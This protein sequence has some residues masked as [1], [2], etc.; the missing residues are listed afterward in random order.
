MNLIIYINGTALTNNEGETHSLPYVFFKKVIKSLVVESYHL[1]KP[2]SGP[3]GFLGVIAGEGDHGY[4]ANLNDVKNKIRRNIRNFGSPERII[5]FGHSRGGLIFSEIADWMYKRNP[6]TRIDVLTGDITAGPGVNSRDLKVSPNI[7][8][9]INLVPKNSPDWYKQRIQKTADINAEGQITQL[10]GD[11]SI[12][13][14]HNSV[15]Y[16]H[17]W[18]QCREIYAILWAFWQGYYTPGKPV[19]GHDYISTNDTVCTVDMVKL[20]YFEH[21][22]INFTHSYIDEL[23]A[24]QTQEILHKASFHMPETL[25]RNVSDIALGYLKKMSPDKQLY[26][27]A[28]ATWPEII[29]T[30]I[31]AESVY[32]YVA[33]QI[34][35]IFQSVQVEENALNA[36]N[37]LER[38]IN[39]IVDFQDA[40]LYFAQR[41]QAKEGRKFIAKNSGIWRILFSLFDGIQD[42]DGRVKLSRFISNCCKLGGE[43]RLTLP[44]LELCAVSSDE[45]ASTLGNDI[46][47]VKGLGQA[48]VKQQYQGLE[49]SGKSN[50]AEVLHMPTC[51]QEGAECKEETYDNNMFSRT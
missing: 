41:N 34:R 32:R 31:S 4:G 7:T 17:T 43:K 50:Q 29:Q 1:H 51:S 44:P 48:V 33:N 47:M 39:C 45:V 21:K 26:Y 19:N 37:Q 14:S 8:S 11:I 6:D 9:W 30:Y 49:M 2:L 3:C 18:E 36:K 40:D 12:D 22:N 38:R 42:V 13:G 16:V 20:R 35:W 24:A 46:C 28:T 27:M 5:L 25:V 23:V 10:Y 15:L